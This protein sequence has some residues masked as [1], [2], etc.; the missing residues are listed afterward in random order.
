[1]SAID[2]S[3]KRPVGAIMFFVGILLLGVI[4]LDKLSINL[5][6]DL[7]Y[8]KL[9]VLTQYPGSGPEEIEK[10]ITAK[11]EAPLSSIP[12]IKEITS[13]SKEGNSIITLEFHW[14]TDMDFALLH[15]KEKTTEA[16]HVLPDDCDPPII[17]EWDPSSS[18]ILVIVLQSK[19]MS[20]KDLKETAE[21]IIVPRLEQLE[22]ISKVEIRGGFEEEISVEIDPGRANN[23]GVSLS[24]V[25]AAIRQN[26]IFRSGGMVR[27]DKYRYTLKIEAE[28]QEPYEIEEIV[29]KR[30]KGRNILVKD[31]GR[32]FY[33]NKVKQGDIRFDERAVISLLAYR[34]AGGNTVNATLD[35]EKALAYMVEEIKK[36]NK[37]E[38]DETAAP[39]ISGAANGSGTQGKNQAVFDL[40]SV[41]VAREAD[42]IISSINSLRS[43]LLLGAVLAFFV[44]LLFLQ[45]FRD[46]LLVSIV[47]PISIIS[48]FVLMF[49]F[50]VDINIM[51]LGGLVLGVGMFVDNSIIVLESIFRHRDKNNLAPAIIKGTKEVSG[52]I[53]ASTFT[54]ISIFLPVIY[55]YGITGKLFRD[56]ALTVSFSLISSLLVAVTLL[57]ALSGIEAIFKQAY[58]AATT[59]EKKAGKWYFFPLKGVNYIILLPLRIIGNIIFFFGAG[60]FL[61]FKY[62]F[63]YLARYSKILL[64]P[65]FKGFNYTYDKFDRFYHKILDKILDKKIIA[66][67]LS[68]VVLLLIGGSFMLLKKELLPTPDSRKFEI[69][70][71]TMPVFGFEETN[72]IA[73]R[74]ETSLRKNE[75]VDFVFTEVGAV[76]QLAGRSEDMSVNSIHYIVKCKSPRARAQVMEAAREILNLEKEY[77]SLQDFTLFLE[78]NTLSQYLSMEGE[79]FQVKVFYEDIETGKKA[80]GLIIAGIEEMGGVHDLKATTSEGKP[81]F[82]VAFKQGLLDTLAVTKEQIAGFI[83]QAVRGQKAETLKKMQKS[84]DIFVRVPVDGIMEM[85]R[86]LSL[87][88][89]I[90]GSTYYLNDLVEVRE[91]ESIKEIARESQERYFLVSGDVKGKNLEKFIARAETIMAGIDLPRSTRFI[92]SGEEEERRKAFDSLNQ[93]IWLAIILVYMI[94]A[95]KFEN[96]FQPFIIMLTVPMGLIGAFLFLLVSGNSLS[97]ISGIGILVL[98]GIGVNDAIVKVEYSNQKR[99]EGMGVREAIL[100]ASKVRLRPILM[101]TFTT[102]FGLIPMAL[103]TQTGAELQR[104]LALVIIGGLLFT[105]FLTLIFI[106]VCYEI[107]ENIREKKKARSV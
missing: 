89:L 102:I 30:I 83:N 105:T 67:V 86:L 31:I 81:I 2:I 44:L 92:F 3:V 94:M 26:H 51:S 11:L 90:N 52:A 59:V 19:A 104:P 12:N 22:G 106:P 41:V 16:E 96:I 64:D 107:L 97:I 46:P 13:V 82:A 5:L 68:I 1:M 27:K 37:D 71:N 58:T 84:F 35:A 56:Q 57:P 14:G 91:I 93:A 20:L 29:V 62:L 42:L 34:E 75:L 87:P 55:L 17:L 24:E 80:A 10:F 7:S 48:T 76:S 25:T 47:I 103:M 70:A 66:L 6:P 100:T 9:T 54:T 32:A 77:T 43:S 39:G 23:I 53:A 78:K 88:V 28:I 72:R 99:R 40:E 8:P 18:P 36:Q 50:K 69:K 73:A 33:K 15:T 74:I 98:I 85:R 60:I 38:E 101:T 79:N 61:F 4:S 49:F 45:N 95:A 63:K 21:F 65:L